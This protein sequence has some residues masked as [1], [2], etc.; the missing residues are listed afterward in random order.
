MHLHSWSSLCSFT[1]KWTRDVSALRRTSTPCFCPFCGSP[2]YTVFGK[3]F[4]Y[5]RIYTL[6]MAYN[7]CVFDMF[8]ENPVKTSIL[9]AMKTIQNRTCIK[10]EVSKLGLLS[11]SI[12]EKFVIVFSNRGSRYV[13]YYVKCLHMYSVKLLYIHICNR[14]LSYTHSWS[15]PDV[16]L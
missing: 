10:F 5:L 4:H 6:I 3:T 2:N 13:L 9:S 14:C 8:K 15:I 16:L 11:T 7:T 12:A 1:A